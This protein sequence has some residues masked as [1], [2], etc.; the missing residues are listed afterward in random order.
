MADIKLS[1][2]ADNITLTLPLS[3]I[4]WT[5]GGNVLLTTGKL[6][7]ADKEGRP[8]TVQVNGWCSP[9]VSEAVYG[10]IP[11]GPRP[12]KKAKS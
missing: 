2:K 5:S 7:V 12:E 3:V 6:E 4:K 11:F 9:E 8:F 10:K 1:A